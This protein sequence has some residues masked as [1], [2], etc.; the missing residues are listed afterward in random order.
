MAASTEEVPKGKRVTRSVLPPQLS[1]GPHGLGDPDDKSLRKVEETIMI[2]AKMKE[3]AKKEKCQEEIIA[4]GK[5][6]KEQGFMMPFKCRGQ[7]KILE[8]C[9]TAWYENEEFQKQCKEEYLEERTF[10]R[11]TGIKKKLRRK[12]AML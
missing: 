10:Y 4:F 3:K 5:C 1:G 8:K 2:P 9:L 11:A 6:S 7:A 12:D